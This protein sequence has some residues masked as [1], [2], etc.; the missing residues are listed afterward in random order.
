MSEYPLTPFEAG[1][2]Y[3]VAEHLNEEIAALAD[4]TVTVDEA[5]ADANLTLH[6]S[7][8]VGTA[9][10]LTEGTGLSVHV[11]NHTYFIGGKQYEIDE[12]AGYLVDGLNANEAAYLYLDTTGAVTP[13]LAKPGTRPEGMYYMGLVTTNG[14]EVAAI[15]ETDADVVASL[16]GVQADVLDLQAAVGVPYTNPVDVDT[17]L[18]TIEDIGGIGGAPVVPKLDALVTTEGEDV[19]QV[20]DGAAA[21]AVAAH[22]VAL[23]DGSPTSGLTEDPYDVDATNQAKALL[24]EIAQDNPLAA[25]T[26]IDAVTIVWGIYGDGTGTTP[27]YVDRVNSTWI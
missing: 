23:H 1:D 5:H 6:G 18:T 9:S 2:S 12:I 27:D 7:G 22:V 20:A 16:T 13:Y 25:D 4:E 26:Q 24:Q 11:L 15:D 14:T 21:D 10:I 17:R 19:F 3:G 8:K